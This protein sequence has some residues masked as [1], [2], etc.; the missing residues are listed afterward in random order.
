LH[1]FFYLLRDDKAE[2]QAAAAAAA[3]HCIDAVTSRG[4]TAAFKI[5][6]HT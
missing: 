6:L 1:L 2:H 4:F 5:Y 3:W